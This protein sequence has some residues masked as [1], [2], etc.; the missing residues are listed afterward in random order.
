M[1]RY[2]K[3]KPGIRKDNKSN[4]F[5]AYKKY[6]RV[7]YTKTFKKISDAKRWLRLEWNELKFERS[8]QPIFRRA[9]L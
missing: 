4:H 9:C 2:Q 5:Q 3:I 6:K 7:Q 8:F 1:K